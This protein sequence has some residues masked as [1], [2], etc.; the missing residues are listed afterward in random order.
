MKTG[1]CVACGMARK[2]SNEHAFPSWLGKVVASLSDPTVENSGKV[3]HKYEGTPDSGIIREWSANETDVKAQVVCE[4][5]NSGWL[6]ELEKKTIPVLTPLVEGRSR[7]LPTAECRLLTRWFL[8]TVLMLEL[9]GDRTQR[10]VPHVLEEWLRNNVQPKSN[11]TLWMGTAREPS[12]IA[13]AGR[14]ADTKIGSGIP[15]DA[16]MFALILG[17]VIFVALG[18][19]SGARPPKLS[20]PMTTALAQVWLPPLVISYPRRVRFSPDQVPL[21]LHMLS[22][23]LS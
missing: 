10:V 8:K 5:C 21:V 1:V 22:A 12:G 9:A 17:H 20:R 14:S 15:Q 23:S 19:S 3:E 7:T 16:W 4:P 6:S 18:T 11:F 2:L 13:T